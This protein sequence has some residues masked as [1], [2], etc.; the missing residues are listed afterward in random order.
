V[1]CEV[2]IYSSSSRTLL[3]CFVLGFWNSELSRSKSGGKFGEIM[4]M[5]G[6]GSCRDEEEEEEEEADERTALEAAEK[7]GSVDEDVFFVTSLSKC[8]IGSPYQLVFRRRSQ[9][10]LVVVAA[11]AAACMPDICFRSVLLR[12]DLQCKR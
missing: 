11:A 7:Q 3:S 9:N 8:A 4:T 6:V 5:M 12:I 10:P 1:T 2:A